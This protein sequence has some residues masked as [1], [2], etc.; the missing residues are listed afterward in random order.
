M[1]T[2]E[3]KSACAIRA[4]YGLPC[5]RCRYNEKCSTYKNQ[6]ENLKT[7]IKKKEGKE[8]EQK[9]RKQRRKESDL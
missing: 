4:M 9:K 3:M 7:K 8:N 2:G 1:V 6:N 5:D